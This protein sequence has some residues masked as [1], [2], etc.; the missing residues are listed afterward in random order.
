M[1]PPAQSQFPA[2]HERKHRGAR[3]G[4]TDSALLILPGSGTWGQGQHTEILEK[5]RQ[6]L[7]AD[8]PVAAICG[9]TVGLAFAGILDERQHTGNVIDELKATNYR[10]EALYLADQFAVTDG[11]L[12]TAGGTAP[13]EFAYHIFQKLEVYTPQVL[14]A[15]YGLYKTHDPAY[16]FALT[17]AAAATNS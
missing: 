10:G 3:H 5:A 15:W 13:L 17:E 9:A 2:Q 16:F 11:N 7:A 8:I 4:C 1:S 12:I 6:F 14:D